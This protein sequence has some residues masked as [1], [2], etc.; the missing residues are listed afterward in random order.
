MAYEGYS[1][2]KVAVDRGVAFVTIDHPPINLLD[3][4]LIPDLDR[5]GQAQA[6]VLGRAQ[7]RNAGRIGRSRP[8]RPWQPAGRGSQQ[9][10]RQ[11]QP[12]RHCQGIHFPNRPGDPGRR[13]GYAPRLP[14]NLHH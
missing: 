10:R 3:L 1:G 8:G 13:A 12:R 5:V 7:R 6:G 9:R 11:R 4:T 2:L 14:T